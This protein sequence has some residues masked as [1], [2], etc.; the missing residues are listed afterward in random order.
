MSRFVLRLCIRIGRCC[1][2]AAVAVGART[3]QVLVRDPVGCPSSPTR[4]LASERRK[5][6]PDRTAF[7]ANDRKTNCW[8]LVGTEGNVHGIPGRL[9][10]DRSS[11]N[12]SLGIS[13]F[14]HRL[15]LMD[16]AVAVQLAVVPVA[17]NIVVVLLLA[18]NSAH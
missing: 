18:D 10:M 17:D 7:F 12:K 1:L 14:A 5:L 15:V 6:S 2:S 8:A 11:T 13:H 16:K 3:V 4:I 9:P